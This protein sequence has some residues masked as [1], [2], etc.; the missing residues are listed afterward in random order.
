MNYT[1][2]RLAELD[3]AVLPDWQRA[4]GANGDPGRGIHGFVGLPEPV[5]PQISAIYSLTCAPT[6]PQGHFREMQLQLLNQSHQQQQNLK[7]N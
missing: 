2:H 7:V 1:Q 5:P 4:V 6:K 3:A